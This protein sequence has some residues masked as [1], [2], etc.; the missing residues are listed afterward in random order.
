MT[1]ILSMKVGPAIGSPSFLL[2]HR[3][4]HGGA[5]RE[6]DWAWTPPSGTRKLGEDLSACVS[7][8]LLEEVGW[9]ASARPV[10]T[11]GVDWAVFA[12]E[13]PWGTDV[14]VDGKEHDRFEWLSFDEARRRCRPIELETSFLEGSRNSGWC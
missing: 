9:Q 6:G 10:L 7:R 3:T 12:L 13:V 14:L 2:L 11:D 1:F 4:H 8:E 5:S